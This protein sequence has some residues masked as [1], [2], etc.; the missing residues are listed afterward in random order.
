MSWLFI[1]CLPSSVWMWGTHSCRNSST[2]DYWQGVRAC[3]DVQRLLEEHTCQDNHELR[4]TMRSGHH[5]VRT[6]MRSG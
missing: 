1:H 4:T 5:E 2:H 3:R 6:T